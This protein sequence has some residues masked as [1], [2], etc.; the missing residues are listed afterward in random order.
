[1]VEKV[2]RAEL[3]E[4]IVQILP[5][6]GR[7]QPMAGVSLFRASTLTELYHSV[8]EPSFCLIAQG[9]KQILVGKIPYRYDPYHYLLATM[10][11][12][13]VSQ[14][15]EANQRTPYLSFRLV[16]DTHLVSSVIV[17]AG[18]AASSHQTDVSAYNVSP[19]N[20][21]LLD[22]VLRLVRLFDT[23]ED[24]PVMAPLIKR[25][26]VFRLLKGAQG[27]RLRHIAI[28]GGHSNRITRAVAI[29]HKNF[30]QPLSIENIAEEMNMSV[31]G[32]HQHFKSVTGMTPLQFQKQLRLQEARRLMLSDNLDAASAGY[33]VGYND[34]SHFSRDYKR[35]FGQPPAQDIERLRQES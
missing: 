25:E 15:V 20:A 8:L 3:V 17:E 18:H 28:L 5:E 19:I 27:N 14:V 16:L 21:G 35:L 33:R 6:D 22:T 12:P 7:A 2:H 9:S 34:A 23:P 13:V 26:L 29:L 31:S 24:I 30:D 32:F 4:R 10:E 1:M 11:L